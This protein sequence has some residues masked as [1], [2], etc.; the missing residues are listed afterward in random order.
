MKTLIKFFAILILNLC[1]IYQNALSSDKIK[2]G[3]IVP[4]TGEYSEIGNSIIKSTR[5]AINKIDDNRIE[6]IPKDTR[7]NPIDALRVSKNLHEEGIKIIIGPVFNESIKYLDELK[8]ITFLSFTNKIIDNPSNVISA[9]VNA[10]SQ[11][12]TIKKFSNDKN[13]KRSVF[14]IPKTDYKKEIEVAIVKSNIKLKDVFFYD[15]EPTLLTKQIEE[16]TRYSQRKR[17]L[18]DEI[19]KLENSS[20][21]NKE[22]KIEKLKKKDTL[23]GINFDSVIIADFD[24]GLKSVATSL[25][26]T[27]VSS[28]RISYITLNQWFDKTLLKE[29]SLQPIYF[30]SINKENYNEFT[31]NFLNIYNSK[32]NQLSFLSYDLV[33]LVYF[34]LYQNKF[35]ISK[36]MFYKKNKFKG[37]IGIFE[38]DKN[39]ITHKLNFYSVEDNQFKKIF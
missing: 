30:P 10:I 37:K 35:K 2:I 6:I 14:L 5:M 36:K 34:L 16:L 17:R 27:D 23:G 39:V 25:L 33:G 1:P 19:K 24:E 8:D 12:N 15:K 20:I 26:Y 3:L 32:P 22:K 9:G 7:S 38:I 21:Q 4:L 28:K 29:T 31:N 13:L 11:I 18:K